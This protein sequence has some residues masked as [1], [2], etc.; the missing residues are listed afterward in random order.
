DGPQLEKVA[1]RSLRS[2]NGAERAFSDA[3]DEA[4]D[5]FSRTT[6]DGEVRE[7]DEAD[8]QVGG[9]VDDLERA[10]PS[11]G[12]VEDPEVEDAHLI[13]PEKQRQMLAHVR[14][15]ASVRTRDHPRV[16]LD[17]LVAQRPG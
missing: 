14:R 9:F 8:D 11:R 4:E 1:T 2:S 12:A 7:A 3:L 13:E 5:S 6:Q 10:E 17:D 16:E 15:D